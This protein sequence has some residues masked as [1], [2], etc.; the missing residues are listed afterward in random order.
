MLSVLL[1]FSNNA[2]LFVFHPRNVA[3][4]LYSPR[5]YVCTL[6]PGTNLWQIILMMTKEQ[7]YD[8]HASQNL[9]DLPPSSSCVGLNYLLL[10]IQ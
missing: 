3:A 5:P 10:Y 2:K 4:R 7:L 6:V 8:P 9:V 1:D